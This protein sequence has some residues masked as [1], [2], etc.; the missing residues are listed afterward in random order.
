MEGAQWVQLEPP[1]GDAAAAGPG[2]GNL[3]RRPPPCPAPAGSSYGAAATRLDGQGLLAYGGQGGGAAHCQQLLG[4]EGCGGA[5]SSMHADDAAQT[6]LEEQQSTCAALEL[7]RMCQ[8]TVAGTL[9]DVVG[10]E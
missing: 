1:G 3:A 6:P 2:C 8:R 7:L 5:H 10:L 4:T 9:D